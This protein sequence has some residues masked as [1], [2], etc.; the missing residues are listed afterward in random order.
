MNKMKHYYLLF[1]FQLFYS[2]IRTVFVFLSG[3]LFVINFHDSVMGDC[4]P[5]V[6]RNSGLKI[7]TM[8]I[9]IQRS[10]KKKIF[11]ERELK[12][13]LK[14]SLSFVSSASTA[15]RVLYCSQREE[16]IC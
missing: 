1:D 2:L 10:K 16:V 11:F 6:P 5:G 8:V 13:I 9:R 4:A 7:H 15:E 12:R 14:L 3:T